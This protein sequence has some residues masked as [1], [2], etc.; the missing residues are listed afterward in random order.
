MRCLSI[1]LA[2]MLGFSANAFGQ[3]GGRGQSLHDTHCLMCHDTRVYTR[4]DRIAN[5]RDR[6]RAEVSRW[7]K[8]VAL[9]WAEADVDA[10]TDFIAARY[11][12]LDCATSC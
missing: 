7:Q 10:V 1:V 8:A 5:D 9:N 4:G 3:D 6:V 12:R 11:Y 2:L